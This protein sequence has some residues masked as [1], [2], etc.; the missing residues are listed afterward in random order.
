MCVVLS[1]EHRRRG[2]GG[3]GGLGLRPWQDH[4]GI[5]L[6]LVRGTER[7]DQREGVLWIVARQSADEGRQHLRALCAGGQALYVFCRAR[8]VVL[9]PDGDDRL[10]GLVALVRGRLGLRVGERAFG[11]HFRPARDQPLRDAVAHFLRGM[12]GQQLQR[13]RDIH[14][15]DAVGEF[16]EAVI[17]VHL[18]TAQHALDGGGQLLKGQTAGGGRVADGVRPRAQGLE[19]RRRKEGRAVRHDGGGRCGGWAG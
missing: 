5:K 14:G 1:G 11:I 10:H 6:L 13:A 3:G 17:A 15:I 4:G 9:G 18:R 19:R 2:L 8:R 12:F 16:V 7:L